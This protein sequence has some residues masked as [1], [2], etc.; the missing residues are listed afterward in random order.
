MTR[1]IAVTSGKGGVGKTAMTVNLAVCLAKLGKNVAVID[2]DIQMANLALMVGMEGRPINLQD[3]LVQEA[4][5]IDGVYEMKPGIKVLPAKLSTE[6]IE[7][8][9]KQQFKEVVNELQ[10]RFKPDIILFDTAPGMGE[11]VQVPLSA[12][13]E[14]IVVTMPESVSVADS[15]KAVMVAERRH[16]LKVLGA[17]IN[18]KK[19]LPGEMGKK[20]IEKII[21]T[22]ALG[23]VPEDSL[24]R[25]C[26]L[27][28]VPV[29]LKNPDAPSSIAVMN[30]AAQLVGVAPPTPE[31]IQKKGI[32]EQIKELLASILPKHKPKLPS[33]QQIKTAGEKATAKPKTPPPVK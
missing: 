13:T 3:I 28:G 22:T 26:S 5:V 18:M 10:E 6:K 20:E 32:I 16:S 29:T 1:I 24:L 19:D 4:N 31:K 33:R 25:R 17:I 14:A 7:K 8:I 30:I 11:E 27:E 12:A 2:T 23:V 15:M 9:P 21:G